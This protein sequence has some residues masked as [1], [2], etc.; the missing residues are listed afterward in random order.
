MWAGQTER[1]WGEADRHSVVQQGKNE[2]LANYL[3]SYPVFYKAEN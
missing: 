1:V 3:I 2:I